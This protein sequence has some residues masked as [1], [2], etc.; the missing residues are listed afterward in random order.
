[1]KI[2]FLLFQF[3]PFLI[4]ANPI[5]YFIPPEGWECIQSKTLSSQVQVA[6]VGKGNT[7]FRPSLN[8]A[9]EE[10]DV[11]LKEYLKSVKEIHESEMKVRWRDLGAFT[12]QAGQGRLGQVTSQ[13]PLGEVQMLQGILVQGNFAYILTAAVLKQEFAAFQP[14]LLKTLHSLTVIPDLFAAIPDESQK[15][16][17]QQTFHHYD[18]LVDPEERQHEWA[19][20]QDVV[21]KDFA[22]LGGCWHFLILKEGYTH[23]FADHTPAAILR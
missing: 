12:F 23:I 9:I 13:S 1:M 19:K 5:C 10:V 15:N 4:A 8:L 18:Q 2:F 21:L 6:F 16:T 11:P 22:S 20:L 7:D 3:I 14:I 17:L